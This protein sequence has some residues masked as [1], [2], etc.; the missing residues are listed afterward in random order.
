MLHLI[1]HSWWKHRPSLRLHDNIFFWFRRLNFN[2]FSIS[3]FFQII[4]MFYLLNHFVV[5]CRTLFLQ[6][7]TALDWVY[8]ALHLIFHIWWKHRS[9]LRPHDNIIFLISTFY[10]NRL[11]SGWLLQLVCWMVLV[12]IRI[13]LFIFS[14]ALNWVFLLSCILYNYDEK[15]SPQVETSW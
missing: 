2:N 15:K 5:S 13:Q 4:F 11:N 14:C 7:F 9:S 12:L 3:V 10:V 1:F 6:F 8:V